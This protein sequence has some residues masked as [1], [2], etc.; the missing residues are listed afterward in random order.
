MPSLTE[1]EM[2]DALVGGIGPVE[3]CNRYGKF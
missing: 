1:S 2:R 3:A